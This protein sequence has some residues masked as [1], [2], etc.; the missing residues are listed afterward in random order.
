MIM[1]KYI[2]SIIALL[3]MGF[4][5]T[6]CDPETNEEPGGF[7]IV[8]MTGDW[9]VTVDA[10]MEDGTVLEDPYGMGQINIAT[11]ATTNDDTDKMWIDDNNNFWQ[12][13][14]LVPIDY[15]NKTFACKDVPYDDVET[16]HATITNGKITKDGG[17]NIHGKPVDAITFDI[18]FDDDDSGAAAWRI[19]GVRYQGFTE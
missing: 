6:S 10:V 7:K 17:L 8:D 4:A 19:H 3:T 5:F 11:Y 18:A 2:F 14:F 9:L 15:N 1:K 13:K 16:G 12:F